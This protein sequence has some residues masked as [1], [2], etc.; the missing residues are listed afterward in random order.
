[1]RKR[2]KAREIALQILYQIDIMQDNSSV[3][4]DNFWQGQRRKMD[5]AVKEFAL[6]LVKGTQEYRH[7]IDQKISQY[8]KNWQLKRMAVVDRNILRQGCF[9]LLYRPDIP[10]RVTINEAIDLAKRFSGLEAGKFVNAI[11]DK[12]RADIG[13]QN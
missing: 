6:E 8:A 5:A 13:K 10:P 3:S 7:I 1:M 9:E 11:L 2:T 12:I 4:L